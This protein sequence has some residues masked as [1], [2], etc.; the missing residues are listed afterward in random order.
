VNR[1][2]GQVRELADRGLRSGIN[3]LVA[4]STL[5]AA[6]RAAEFV[7]AAGIGNDRIVYLPMRVRETPTPEELPDLGKRRRRVGG[8]S[9]SP[10]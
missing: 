4:R 1:V 5:D 3:F 10:P 9:G 6:R 2:I 7:R 8:R